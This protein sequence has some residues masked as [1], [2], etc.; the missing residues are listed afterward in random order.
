MTT[1]LVFE[2]DPNI[3]HIDHPER[4]RAYGWS[5]S[6]PVWEYSDG[7]ASPSKVGVKGE[8]VVRPDLRCSHTI[9]D[10]FKLKYI[11]SFLNFYF[12]K[13]LVGL[14][15][16]H[17]YREGDFMKEHYDTRLPDKDGLPHIMTM[18]VTDDISH[19]RVN[20]KTV[21]LTK[22]KR[23][24]YGDEDKYIVLFTL[25]C[26]HEIIQLG[27][28]KVRTSFAFPVYGIYDPFFGLKKKVS[29]KEPANIY[30]KLLEI[31]DNEE[32]EDLA[33]LQGYIDALEDFELSQ[34]IVKYRFRH[35]DSV[36]SERNHGVR[37]ENYECG[38]E[39]NYVT[40]ITYKG[41]IVVLSSIDDEFSGEN[42][43]VKIKVPGMDKIQERILVLKKESEIL[44]EK[45]E[46]AETIEL[47]A[48]ELPTEQPFTVLLAG[49]YFQ[50][51]TESDLVP[52]DRCLY[53]ALL[54]TG[55]QVKFLPVTKFSPEI[56]N[57]V[58]EDG[59]LCNA[60]GRIGLNKSVS[61]HSFDVEFDDQGGYDSCLS[62]AYG[63]LLV[64]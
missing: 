22:P 52:I 16:K 57:Y 53:E 42:F 63:C 11:P 54:R 21:N 17:I 38:Y 36:P 55:R 61:I 37:A 13:I 27:K 10:K 39:P 44:L 47:K 15:S 5:T 40:E 35:G 30:D 50:D 29:S 7:E 6:D 23:N 12:P 26:P 8:L 28:N 14:G 25:N 45:N 43:S 31:I 41:K 3:I 34:E 20:G 49:R 4:K 59:K 24:S 9:R 18:L 1:C 62:L 56:T 2:E 32:Y 33:E 46:R 64:L 51:S 60:Q 19:L 48:S 58:L